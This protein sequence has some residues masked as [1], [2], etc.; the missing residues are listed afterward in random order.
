MPTLERKIGIPLT[1]GLKR[2]IFCLEDCFLSEFWRYVPLEVNRICIDALLASWELESVCE[3]SKLPVI[4]LDRV[5]ISEADAYLEVTRLTDPNTGAVTIAPRPGAPALDE[6]M[7]PLRRYKRICLV[8]VGAFE[9]STLIEVCKALEDRDISIEDI[10]LGFSSIGANAAINNDR[11]MT[12]L[13]LFEFYEWIELRDLFAIDG[14]KV[15]DG[16]VGESINRFIPYR[17]N[18]G[19][20]ASI[21]ESFVLEVRELCLRYERALV[22]L[23]RENCCDIAKI[24]NKVGYFGGK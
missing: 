12:P 24:G 1:D 18:L 11:K 15:A 10:F 22:D 4:S 23:L 14:R 17:E 19:K 9:G 21:P 5:Y 7:D 20:W 2:N 6:Q 8:D 13:Y 16:A 3:M